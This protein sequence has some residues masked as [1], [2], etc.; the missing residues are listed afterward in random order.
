VK[1]A[2]RSWPT[3]A[4][5][6]LPVL[7]SGGLGERAGE[8]EVERPDRSGR[9]TE[10]TIEEAELAR[11]R[12]DPLSWLGKR[13]HFVLQLESTQESWVPYLSRFGPR[14]WLGL[15][16]WPDER[17]TWIPEVYADPLPHLFVRRGTRN[18]KVLAKAD[19]YARF[20]A[21]GVVREVFLG[22]PW[23]EIELL[24]ALPTQVGEGTI[25][26]VERALGL[27]RSGSWELA[28][29][30]LAR[31]RAAP[32]PEHARREIERLEGV[33]EKRRARA[34]KGGKRRH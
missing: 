8:E 1:R 22:E 3:L 31:A 28:R 25:L 16:A 21:R 24:Q 18:E 20:R 12:E 14:D 5:L 2:H 27:M 34:E 4:L 33:I 6:V 15:R 23:I 32:L 9:Q 13:I 26:H 29:E 17:F 7:A 19:R 11:V 10:A 30:Q